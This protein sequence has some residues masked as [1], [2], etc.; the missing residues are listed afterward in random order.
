[1]FLRIAVPSSL[2]SNSPLIGL[3]ELGL[4][5][6]EHKG[7]MN[8]QNT[9]NYLPSDTAPHLQRHHLEN[10]NPGGLE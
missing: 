3:T 2:G 7:S 10:L 5:D 6:P 8:L 9:G 1:M 4:L